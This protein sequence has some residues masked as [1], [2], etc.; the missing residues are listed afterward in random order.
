MNQEQRRQRLGM[1]FVAGAAILFASKGLFAKAL[2]QR[3]VGFEL[4]VAVRAV[5]RGAAVRL[6]RGARQCAGPDIRGRRQAAADAPARSPRGGHRRHHLLLRRRAGGFLGA[7]AHRCVDRTRAAVQ[8]SGDG[9]AHRLGA[10]A[11]RAGGARGRGHGRHLHR[12]LLRHGRHRLRRAA[13]KPVRRVAGAHRRAHHGYLLP[14]RRTIHARARQHA[15][16]RH[17]HERLGA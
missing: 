4:L 1:L 7:D 8:L 11:P 2:Y 9:G 12:H 15:L 6:V 5:H 17:R 14:D 3:G 13:A 16:R 10:Q